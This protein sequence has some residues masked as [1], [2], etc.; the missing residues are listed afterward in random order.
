MSAPE[1]D[2][3]PPEKFPPTFYYANAIELFERLAFYG[4]FVGLV[5]F[6]HK[7]VGYSD[8]V[9]SPVVGTYRLVAALAPIVCGSIA[10]RIRFKRSLVVAFVLYALGYG[11]LFAF[12]SPWLAPV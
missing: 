8:E 9:A 12:P 6:L 11:S 7:V 4:T 5:L 1:Q 10:D 3:P 2:P